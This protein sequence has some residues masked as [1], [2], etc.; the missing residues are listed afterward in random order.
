MK[1]KRFQF[2]F[3]PLSGN[4]KDNA[5]RKMFTV[6]TRAASLQLNAF[7]ASGANSLFNPRLRLFGAA[8]YG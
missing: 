2:Q 8:N 3:L 6:H 1:I 4:L 7:P 5:A